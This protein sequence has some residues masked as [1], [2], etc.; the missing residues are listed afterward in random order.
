[1]RRRS[2]RTMRAH[3][4]GGDFGF[5]PGAPGQHPRSAW[6]AVLLAAVLASGCE[7]SP[8]SAAG[9][10]RLNE[11]RLAAALQLTEERL[12]SGKF[13]EARRDL[14]RFE[15]SDDPRLA[16]LLT[17]IDLEEGDYA[18]ALNR[19]DTCA[20]RGATLAGY[21]R[22]RGTALEGLGRWDAAATA[23]ERAWQV[24]PTAET[25]SAWV[26]ALVLAQRPDEARDVLARGHAVCP[27]EPGLHVAAARLAE[28]AGDANALVQNLEA[29]TLAAPDAVDVRGRLA[30]AY[31]L[32]GR[33]ADAARV[34][35]DLVSSAADRA[36]RAR[37]HRR[38][39]GALAASGQLDEARAAYGVLA[40][41]LPENDSVALALGAVC[42]ASGHAHE[43]LDAI[44]GVLARRP[45]H[46]EA[47]VLAALCH[48]RL[49][50]TPAAVRLLSDVPAGENNDPA[51]DSARRLLARWQ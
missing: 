44:Q 46:V 33:P 17:R 4:T 8:R 27:G 31:T 41:W 21:Q 25:L 42:L 48:R 10:A 43:G 29:A 40:T 35:R 50:D 18:G 45:E 20:D 2:S 28:A 37:Y 19:L 39:A 13:A 36:T 3:S 49:N 12:A 23:Y 26:D 11:T 9:P 47:R 24:A 1:M 34:W 7:T 30:N 14:A 6:P 38:Y 15:G 51:R 22:L 5:C 32:A 16:L